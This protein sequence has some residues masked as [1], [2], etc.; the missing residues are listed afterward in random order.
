MKPESHYLV[1]LEKYNGIELNPQVPAGT[2]KVSW[3]NIDTGE[4]TS[5][6][7]TLGNIHTITSPIDA[8]RQVLWIQ[9][10]P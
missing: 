1:F 2:Y 7:V 4:W 3:L 9:N 6:E 8:K 10:R 5:R